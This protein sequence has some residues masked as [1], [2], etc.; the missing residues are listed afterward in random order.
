MWLGQFWLQSYPDANTN[1]GNHT[2]TDSGSN[3]QPVANSYADARP[4]QCFHHWPG[5]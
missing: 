2:I 3:S 1:A 5:G 4:I